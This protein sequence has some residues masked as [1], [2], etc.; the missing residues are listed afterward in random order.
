MNIDKDIQI[1]VTSTLCHNCIFAEYN[2]KNVQTGCKA[3]RLEKYKKA[4]IPI[5]KSELEKKIG[6]II[7]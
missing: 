7:E 5:L 6:F 3:N 2:N 4:N 1:P